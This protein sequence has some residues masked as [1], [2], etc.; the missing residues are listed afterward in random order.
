M[1]KKRNTIV[2][3]LL[4]T[5]FNIIVFF[6]VFI[7]LMALYLFVISP[8]LLSD[9]GFAGFTTA[10]LI[11]I[12]VLSIGLAF[13]IYRLAVNFFFKRINPEKHFAPLL[14]KSPKKGESENP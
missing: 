1:D 2:F 13:F 8:Y 3:I 7:A 4:A 6:I 9:G 11:V 10:F 14:T 5:V 12:F